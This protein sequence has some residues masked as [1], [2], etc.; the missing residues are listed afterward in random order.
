MSKEINFNTSLGDFVAMHPRARKVFEKFELDYCCG[1][2]EDIKTAAKKK[3][4]DINELIS[5]LGKTINEENEQITEKIWI[6]ES[7]TD[8]INHIQTKHHE[9]MWKELPYV[10]KLLDKIVRVHGQKHG[11][12]LN[13][14]SNI[15]KNLKKNLEKHLKDEENLLFPY[16]KELETSTK[17]EKSAHEKDNFQDILRV[18]YEEHDEAG[19]AL[20]QIRRLTSNY[21]LP[22]DACASFEALYENLQAIEDDLHEHVHLENTVLFPRIEELI[23]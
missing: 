11:D 13:D 14:L 19:E 15:Y 2:K 12:F 5:S 18:L 3:N 23:N 9:F 10:D 6:N 22:E 1:G 20:S 7:L 8:I 17:N 4:V 21:I 16:V